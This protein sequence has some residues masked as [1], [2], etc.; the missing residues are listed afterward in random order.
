MKLSAIRPV[1]FA[2]ALALAAVTCNASGEGNWLTD[3]K[4]AQAEANTSHKNILM[5]FTGSDWCPVCIQM[6]K[7]VLDTKE[8]EKYA[9]ENLVLMKVDFPAK[10]QLPQKEQDQNSD[11]QKK[12]ASEGFLPTYVLVD[13]DGNVLGR[14]IGLVEGGP[15]AF[16]TKLESMKK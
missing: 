13:K 2:A 11:L 8:F 3:F 5:D 16:I 12:Y 14:Q 1:F 7:T 10:A 4:A 9:D 6:T 15:S